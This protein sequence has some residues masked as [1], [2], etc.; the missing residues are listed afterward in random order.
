MVPKAV[1][2]QRQ[3]DQTAG[4]P[5]HKALFDN[6]LPDAPQAVTHMLRT[7]LIKSILA[8]CLAV[9]I[10]SAQIITTIAG[11]TWKF[12]GNSMPALQAPLGPVNGLAIAPSG[13]L[14][15]AA[16]LGHVVLRM[17]SA[18]IVTVVAGNALG[19]FSGD[20]GP[21]TAASLDSPLGVAVDGH[22]S[23]FI[24][25][26]NNGRIRK[27]DS[28]GVITTVA[29]LP[30]P[31]GLATAADGSLY[32]SE[33]LNHLVVRITPTG[34]VVPVAGT[35]QAGFSGDG[36]PATSA[37]LNQPNGLAV[38][39]QGN[40]Y[41][42]DSLNFRIRQ[43]KPDGTIST[44]AGDGFS[45]FFTNLTLDKVGNLYASTGLQIL[46]IN[47]AGSVKVVAGSGTASGY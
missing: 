35:G 5:W 32:A 31:Y 19:G 25:D 34:S 1:L 30:H 7:R 23:L 28:Q 21:A 10:S 3:L 6:G 43:V 16:N 24:A 37:K 11:T 40:L 20:G 26:S 17:N 36:G 42:A 45:Q 41:I 12:P 29:V 18:G 13:D 9:S 46:S 33:N 15:A 44:L 39:S 4:G 47:P 2:Q 8:L 22:G 38:D 14:L 27:V